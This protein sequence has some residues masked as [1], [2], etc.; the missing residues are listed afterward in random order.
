LGETIEQRF[1]TASIFWSRLA[2]FFIVQVEGVDA[3]NPLLQFSLLVY[4]ENGEF[5]QL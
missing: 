4:F 2:R 1:A 3:E 5:L